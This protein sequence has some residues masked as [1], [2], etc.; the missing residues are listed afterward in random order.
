[1]S[2]L[3]GGG[4]VVGDLTVSGVWRVDAADLLAGRV[5]T[6]NGTV[7]LAPETTIHVD[8]PTGLLQAQD[9]RRTFQLIR[10]TAISGHAVIE[11]DNLDPP[12]GARVNGAAVQLG[13]RQGTLIIFH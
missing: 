10:A 8:D 3:A 4:T 6:V 13:Y 9:N 11:I 1:M 12:W 2:G 5:L 7:T